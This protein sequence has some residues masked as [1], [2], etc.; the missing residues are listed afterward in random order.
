VFSLAY[1]SVQEELSSQGEL[2]RA[3]VK[4]SGHQ[5][6]G[7]DAVKVSEEGVIFRS[8]RD[9]SK[10]LM[11]PESTVQAQKEIESRHYHSS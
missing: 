11:T 8:Y 2:K 7:P 4:P 10:F 6:L 9:G 5:L 1:G 3:T